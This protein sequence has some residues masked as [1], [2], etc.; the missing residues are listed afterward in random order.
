M[1]I[2]LNALQV[3]AAK[4][5]VGH[6]VD[7]LVDGLLSALAD[8]DELIVYATPHNAPN[9]ERRA[10]NFT[11][12]RFGPAA[13]RP[14]RLAYEW[15][16]LPRRIERDGI[17]V[18]HGAANFLPRR[19]PCPA[20]VTIHDVSPW[21]QPE[22]FPFLRRHYWYAMTR[23]TLRQGAPII[24]VSQAAQR[25]L[26]RY[27]GVPAERVTV[28]PEAAHPRYRPLPDCRFDTEPLRRYGI[29]GPFI[30]HV[31]TLEPG[32]NIPRLLQAFARFRARASVDYRLVLAGDR[33][34]L[35]DEI[36]RAI[37]RFGLRERVVVAGHVPDDHLPSLYNASEFFVFPSLNEGFGLPPL[38]AMACAKP[39]IASN[40][41]SL[42]EVL[43]EAPLY[44]DPL[45]VE[46]L[47]QAMARLAGDADLRDRLAQA[48][49]AQAARYSWEK[50]GRLTLEAYQRVLGGAWA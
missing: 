15:I 40:A 44:V 4:S 12:Q 49:Q 33:G 34:W 9:Y 10:S 35:Y 22:R 29:G 27:L 41:S 43:G 30:L 5:G 20:I 3:R 46:A 37:D 18:F 8:D 2:G 1:K 7:G 48:G 17:D 38:E 25:D 13:R 45:D 28:I 50:T 42:P 47:A 21:V 14:A 24:A 31:G 32:K 19:C 16:G 6:Y 39:V 26:E 23:R 11:L 36:F